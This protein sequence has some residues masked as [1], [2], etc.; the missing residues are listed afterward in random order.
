MD[1]VAEREGRCERTGSVEDLISDVQVVGKEIEFRTIRN[2][3]WKTWG[4][5]EELRNTDIENF[6]GEIGNAVLSD[7][8]RS[9]VVELRESVTRAYDSEDG[10]YRLVPRFNE[11]GQLEELVVPFSSPLIEDVTVQEMYDENGQFQASSVEEQFGDSMHKLRTMD[12]F[13]GSLDEDW[14]DVK[15]YE[16]VELFEAMDERVREMDGTEEYT[17]RGMFVEDGKF[18]VAAI[19]SW[20]VPAVVSL[21]SPLLG[22]LLFVVSCSFY[23]L[24][25]VLS[26][27][28]FEILYHLLLVVYA[29]VKNCGNRE[30]ET[31]FET[32]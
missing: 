7:D 25:V 27:I 22:I 9:K 30:Y 11:E 8:C 15:T 20:G 2:Q 13:V 5:L 21:F 32:K 24:L 17:A 6:G 3:S 1:R 18:L 12:L 31:V 28:T 29:G 14:Y 19:L 4:S 26:I 10:F 16:E 23:L